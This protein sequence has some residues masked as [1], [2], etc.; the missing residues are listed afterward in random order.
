[1]DKDSRKGIGTTMPGQT[2]ASKP[3]VPPD[4][5]CP[6]HGGYRK[7]RTFRIAQ[8]I[9]DGTVIFCDRFIDKRSRTH[10]QMVQAARSGKQNIA[11]GSVASGTSKKMEFKLT[12]VANASLEEL[13]QDYEDF[14]RQ[15]G[16]P[17]WDKDSPQALAVRGQYREEESDGSDRSDRSDLRD[18]YGI[19]TASPEVAANTLLCLINQ[20]TYL[21]KRQIRRLERDFLDQG[22]ITERLFRKRV[23]ARMV[24]DRS[25]RSD[26]SDM[27][28]APS[29]PLCGKSMRRRIARQGRNAGKPFWGCSA[30]PDCK[31]IVAIP[32]NGERSQP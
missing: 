26:G 4:P 11:E 12:N 3:P 15:R 7:L 31:G 24:S 19:A 10:D 25:D 16:L 18:P 2:D 29:C 1:M 17:I 22:G 6:P 20:D 28:S 14:L 32:T 9:Y 5:I 21:L 13:L 23:E 8:L 30:Y 27:V